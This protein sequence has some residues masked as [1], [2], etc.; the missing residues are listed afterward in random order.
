[1]Q[2]SHTLIPDVSRVEPTPPNASM[3]RRTTF[4]KILLM[5][6]NLKEAIRLTQVALNKITQ[7]S[8]CSQLT[9][10]TLEQG[11]RYVQLTIKLLLT[12]II[13]HPLVLVFLLLTL[14]LGLLQGDIELL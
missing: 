7:P 12:S 6:I 14:T 1:M 11:V 2:S 8:T 4:V 5:A 13:F 9:I 10:K 3:I